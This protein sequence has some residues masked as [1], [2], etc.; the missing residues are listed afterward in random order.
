MMMMIIKKDTFSKQVKIINRKHMS[1]FCLCRFLGL[2]IEVPLD[3][4]CSSSS[5]II[6]CLWGMQEPLTN[7][8]NPSDSDFDI[9]S[10]FD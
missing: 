6:I 2:L 1:S 9:P 3:S 7:L 4:P 5:I 8:A 10:S